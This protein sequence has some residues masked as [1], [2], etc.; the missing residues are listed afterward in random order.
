MLSWQNKKHKSDQIQ[1]TRL[2]INPSL[3]NPLCL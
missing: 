3:I 2:Y 1:T